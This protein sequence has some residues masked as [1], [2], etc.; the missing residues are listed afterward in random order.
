MAS[1]DDKAYKYRQEISQNRQV[2]WNS[3]WET[4][5]AF[6]ACADDTGDGRWH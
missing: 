2:S 4:H 1:K 3:S 5:D 6:Y